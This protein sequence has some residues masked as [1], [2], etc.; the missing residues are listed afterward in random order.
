MQLTTALSETEQFV[1]KITRDPEELL[2]TLKLRYQIFFLEMQ[3][4]Q[5]LFELDFDDFDLTSDHLVVEE[6][7]TKEVVACCR[8]RNSAKT[9]KFYSSQEFE[10]SG[11]IKEAGRK[12]EIGRVCVRKEFRSGSLVLLLWRGLAEYMRSF[13]IQILFG[14]CSEPGVD[15]ANAITVFNKIKQ[16]GK[17]NDK[18]NV[19]QTEAYSNQQFQLLLADPEPAT[20]LTEYHFSSLLQIYLTIGCQVAGPP[21]FDYDFNCTDFLVF[22]EIENLEKRI[23]RK[24]RLAQ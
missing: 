20:G 6:K 22:L 21:A 15:A 11:L 4:R 1:V 2:K 17:L 10:I 19:I 12:V 23:S 24:M 3:G 5:N 7:S 8:L 13:E 16:K 14:C 9:D 18:F